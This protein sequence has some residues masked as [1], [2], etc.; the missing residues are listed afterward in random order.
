MCS[1]DLLLLLENMDGLAAI[2][3]TE[4][5]AAHLIGLVAS[6]HEPLPSVARALLQLA[7]TLDLQAVIEQRIQAAL[8]AR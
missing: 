8:I 5:S 3:L 6:D 1:S 4:P 7:R 2:T